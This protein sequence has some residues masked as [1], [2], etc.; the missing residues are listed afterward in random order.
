MRNEVVWRKEIRSKET[1]Q[2]EMISVKMLIRI[3]VYLIG[4]CFQTVS[5]ASDI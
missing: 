4:D 3:Y 2:E 1:M 5:K